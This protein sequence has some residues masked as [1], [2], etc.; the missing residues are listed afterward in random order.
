MNPKEAFHPGTIEK[1]RRAGIFL[2]FTRKLIYAIITTLTL[3]TSTSD[4][5]EGV[6]PFVTRRPSY[7]SFYGD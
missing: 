4:A 5:E 6:V 3:Y 1:T 7:P 2:F